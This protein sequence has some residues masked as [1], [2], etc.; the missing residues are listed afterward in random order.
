MNEERQLTKI[1]EDQ[2]V[3]NGFS[4]LD[5]GIGGLRMKKEVA[6]Q[7]CLTGCCVDC[8][9]LLKLNGEQWGLNNTV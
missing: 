1:V 8:M 9:L 5:H 2:L 6:K 4:L 7:K 3:I